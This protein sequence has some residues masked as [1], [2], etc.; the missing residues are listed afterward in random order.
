MD[1]R[2]ALA[3]VLVA[4]AVLIGAGALWV[5]I[6]SVSQQK[7]E[8]E[9]GVESVQSDYRWFLSGAP[10]GSLL[11]Y[12]GSD[13][14]GIDEHRV[15]AFAPGGDAVWD[16]ADKAYAT[17]IE[18]GPAQALLLKT[19]PSGVDGWED[20]STLVRVS[21]DGEHEVARSAGEVLLVYADPQ[22]VVYL[23]TLR[24]G[25]G[26]PSSMVVTLS[27]GRRL[28]TAMLGECTVEN[29]GVSGDRLVLAVIARDDEGCYIVWFQR[30]PGGSWEFERR[31]STDA[32]YISLS[33]DGRQ[34]VL[35]PEQ[36]VLVDRS[37][38]RSV[39]LPVEGIAKARFGPERLLLLDYRIVDNEEMA[40]AYTVLLASNE[41][42]W[43]R[44]LPV[45]PTIESDA[46]VTRLAYIQAG[47]GGVV[48]VDLP[49]R[50]ERVY[51]VGPVDDL[52]FIDS[53]TLHV[54]LRDG[55]LKCLDVGVT[56]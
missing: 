40:V 8:P 18:A 10:E 26:V 20:I 47:E 49:N 46:G 48:V 32:Y 51:E 30:G 41:V 1:R 35:G 56:R 25:L 19:E 14:H 29:V 34:A 38:G 54:A 9:P 55:S 15:T 5:C 36:P 53:D 21:P 42:E 39:S 16:W 22:E 24:D 28:D 33:A 52:V 37:T 50:A 45:N 27:E 43:S 11:S 7:E 23:E 2:R 4:F 13:G 6:A 17:G 12:S 31:E 3:L 44:P